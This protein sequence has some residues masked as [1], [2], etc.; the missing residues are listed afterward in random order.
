[1][2][3]KKVFK[4]REV[5]ANLLCEFRRLRENVQYHDRKQAEMRPAS[6]EI[7]FYHTY[8]KPR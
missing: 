6:D 1:M 3:I 2:S 5:V 4:G 8:E 7:L